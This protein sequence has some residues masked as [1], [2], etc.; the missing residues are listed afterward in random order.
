MDE[1]YCLGVFV[2]IRS[3]TFSLQR[4]SVVDL[5]SE[6][7]CTLSEGVL[8]AMLWSYYFHFYQV[9]ITIKGSK[10]YSLPNCTCKIVPSH[11]YVQVCTLTPVIRV[12]M[13]LCDLVFNA[14]AILTVCLT[15]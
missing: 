10:L 15:L 3:I 7:V 4:S 6:P 12:N 9:C 14:Q 2:I 11:Q 5:C 8:H 1:W 13:L